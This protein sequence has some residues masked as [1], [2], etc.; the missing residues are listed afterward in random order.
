MK[1]RLI[2]WILIGIGALFI[3]KDALTQP[4]P[5]DL[6]GNFKE[7]AFI[8]SKQNSGPVIRLYAVTVSDTVWQQMQQY[9]NYM[10]YNKYGDT[11]VYFF[12][13]KQP[14]P[15]QLTFGPV[16]FNSQFNNQC[17]GVYQKD[18]MSQVK[19]TRYPFA[20]VVNH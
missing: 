4:G 14:Y 9:G 10:P 16:N 15:G 2:F 11:K 12:L 5:A 7:V 20:Q 13:N 1:K 3:I 8:R 18:V 17:L 6:K 19:F